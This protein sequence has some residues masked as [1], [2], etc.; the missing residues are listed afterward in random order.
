MY[1]L[2]LLED[3]SVVITESDGVLLLRTRVP[4]TRAPSSRV[5]LRQQIPA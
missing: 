2:D 4:P 1:L 3:E 5:L